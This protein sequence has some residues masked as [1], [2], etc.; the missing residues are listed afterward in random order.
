MFN[1][2]RKVDEL[3][4]KGMSGGSGSSSK[5]SYTVRMTDAPGPYNQVNVEILG[6]EITGNGGKNIMLNVKPG[7]YNIL[8]YVNGLDTVI[9]TGSIDSGTV[10]QIRL[11]LGPNNSVMVDSVTY[12][13]TVPSGEQSGL[14]IQV[15]QHISA[16]V[17]YS[18]LLDFDANKSI[19]RQGNG[20]YKLKPVIRTINAAISGSIQGSIVP[21]GVAAS[22]SATNGTDTFTS[23]VNLNGNFMIMGLPPGTYD[24]TITPASPYLPVT[25]TGVVVTA[26]LS[27]NMGAINL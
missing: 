21:A 17:A 5:A 27:K 26:G 13:L 3:R 25:V 6:V 1:G 4:N 24:V 19:I 10:E 14:K 16:G 15:H 20:K 12:P 11:I 2:C 9:A 7:I 22:V 23:V 8:D 18:V